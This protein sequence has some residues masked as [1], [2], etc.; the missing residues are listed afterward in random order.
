MSSVKDGI[1][2]LFGADSPIEKIQNFI[3]GFDGLNL[4]GIITAG[5]A[6]EQLTDATSQIPSATQSLGPFASS[7]EDLGLAL[8]GMGDE[9]FKGFA[10]I[11]PHATG[12]G[13]FATSTEQLSN[14]LY[15]MDLSSAS[16]GFFELATSIQSM[17]LY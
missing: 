3:K 15:D 4:G 2:G 13:M 11:E 9:P 8:K 7:M 12:M 5:W 10:G 14:A 16:D 1:G 17:A 6:M